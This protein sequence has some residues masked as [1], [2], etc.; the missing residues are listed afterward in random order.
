MARQQA[1]AAAPPAAALGAGETLRRSRGLPDQI[2]GIIA[3]EIRLG[4]LK[5]GDRL[6]TEQRLCEAYGVSRAVIRE[7]ISRLKQ[8]GLLVS[9][10]GRGVFVSAEGTGSS[11]RL[12]DTNL[13]DPE[14]LRQILELLIAV[15]VAATALAA[16]RRSKKDLTAIGRAL[17][18]MATA[19]ERGESG[20]DEDMRFHSTIV[21]ASGNLYFQGFTAYLE[22]RVRN[23]IRA[24]RTNTARF[25]GLAYKVQEEHEAIYRAIEARD[26]EAARAAA[27]HHLRNAAARLRLYVGDAA[28]KGG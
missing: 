22:A 28:R 17:A 24:A 5:P 7:A 20:V 6:P 2:S 23:L 13:D 16:E 3:E 8:D 25:E 26:I 27:E 19:I 9:Q 21:E 12:P 11:F 14:E 15:E 1:T 10:Q 18:D 4:R